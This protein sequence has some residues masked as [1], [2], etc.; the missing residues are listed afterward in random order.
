[1][2]IPGGGV[3]G[4]TL[5]RVS[6]G[7]VLLG[8][9][10][11]GGLGLSACVVGG[12][13]TYPVDAVFSS[14]PG[15][16]TGNQVDVLGVPVGTVTAVRDA[17]SAVVVRMAI[18][19]KTVLPSGVEASLVT[20]EILGEPS[21]E[22]GPGYTG[23]PRLA[24]GATIPEA[25]TSVPVSTNRFLRDT[26]KYLSQID[27]HALGSLVGNL[28]SD[29]SGQG[30]NLSSLITHAAATLKL[31]AAKGNDLGRLD[32]TLASLLGTLKSRT[33]AI[34]ALIGSYDQVSSVI[35]ANQG[36]LG[37]SLSELVSASNQLGALLAPNISP[38]EKQI[39]TITTV[40][41]TLD[42]NLT[43]VDNLVSGSAT[44]FGAAKRGFST[45]QRYQWLPLNNALAP[46]VSS[47]MLAGMIR[48][49]LAGVCRRILAN[50]SQGLSPAEL[51]TL[52]T[53]GNPASGF[54]DSLLSV[55][56]KVGYGL[57]GGLSGNGAPQVGPSTAPGVSSGQSSQSGA[58][59][60]SPTAASVAPSVAAANAFAKGL[61]EIPGLSQ[62]ARSALLNPSGTGGTGA[63]SGTPSLSLPAGASLGKLPSLP[64]DSQANASA[65]SGSGTSAGSGASAG[66]GGGFLGIGG[67][68]HHVLSTIGSWL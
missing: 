1:M 15:V 37:Q 39:A 45:A 22:L 26:E 57:P 3:V 41:R 25:R 47:Q 59:G 9:L 46:G 50:H 27:P 64:S 24:H 4:S 18:S 7:A 36:P 11:F 67:L 13:S 8:A 62:A 43:Q 35:A 21:V 30:Q 58:S 48:D 53:C 19:S 6:R 32:G 65:G 34:T 28:A 60:S 66:S 56:T 31:L 38:L 20:P 12:S 42:R 49:R 61:G 2:R 23:G 14:G 54:F 16:F 52:A 29:L 5:G 17:G 51:A 33:A 63:S 44:L 55:L 10:V 40:G 68:I